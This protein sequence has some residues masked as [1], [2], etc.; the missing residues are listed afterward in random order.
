MRTACFVLILL[1]AVLHQGSS[2]AGTLWQ[3]AAAGMSPGDIKGLYPAVLGPPKGKGSD[4]LVLRNVA[5]FD[6]T[7]T[8]TFVFKDN[9]LIKVRLLE[10]NPPHDAGF[11]ARPPAATFGLIRDD[12]VGKYGQPVHAVTTGATTELF[13]VHDGTSIELSYI[14]RSLVE[15]DSWLDLLD[16]TDHSRTIVVTYQPIGHGTNPL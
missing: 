6:E 15:S 5:I 7:F 3:G 8:A 2:F 9:A 10:S 16:L 1:A 13:F 12:L 14:D 11:K 4:L